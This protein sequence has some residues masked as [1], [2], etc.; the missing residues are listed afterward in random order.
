MATVSRWFL[1]FCTLKPQGLGSREGTLD[2]LTLELPAGAYTT[3]R[4][5]KGNCALHLEAH[6]Q[7]LEETL[8]LSGYHVILPRS[9]L[10]AT[11][12]L[13]IANKAPMEDVR[14]R[15]LIPMLD[16][17]PGCY[18]FV[19][20]LSVP[21]AW[22][23]QEGAW[24]VT[25]VLSREQPQAKSS[26]FIY[27]TADMRERD[28]KAHPRVNEILMVN[29]EGEI[30]EGLSSNFFAVQEG[31]ILT[32]GHGVLQGVTRSLVIE[33]AQRAGYPLLF[34]AIKIDELSGLEEAFITS[35]SRGVLPLVRIDEITIGNGSPGVITRSIACLY[36]LRV[37]QMVEPI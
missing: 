33:I 5:F 36:A 14:V 19:E 16:K 15:L 37:E 27:Q 12:R 26:R 32:A 13:A 8:R 21:A 17:V 35:S 18:V 24:A 10:R 29:P 3:F 11:I 28:L 22:L 31:H 25:R 34:R 9:E 4:T 30:L 2:S 7:R 20:P 23:Y 6:F 1:D